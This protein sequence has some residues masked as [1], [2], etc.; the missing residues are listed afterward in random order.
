MKIRKGLSPL[1]LEYYCAE[2]NIAFAQNLPLHSLFYINMYEQQ[3]VG[4][5]NFIWLLTAR[6]CIKGFSG[7][8][9]FLA[10]KIQSQR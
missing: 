5:E 4:I 8:E 3:K 1:W 10:T 6:F 7:C 9:V 2:F